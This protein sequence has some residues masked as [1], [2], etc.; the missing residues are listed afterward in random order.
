M[1][2]TVYH[3]IDKRIQVSP[4]HNRKSDK[5]SNYLINL[6]RSFSFFYMVEYCKVHKKKQMVLEAVDLFEKSPQEQ[7]R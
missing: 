1:H 4:G 2:D 3:G 6:D 5:N 7:G